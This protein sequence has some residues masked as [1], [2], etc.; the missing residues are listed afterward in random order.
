MVRCLLLVFTFLAAP[1]L[2][3][4]VE[5]PADQAR[6]ELVLDD[7]GAQ[8]LAGQMVL[9]TIRGIYA[10]NI[11]REELKLRRM[12][13]VDWIRLGQD[14]WSQQR[15]DGRSLRVMERRIALYPKA[16]GSLT[17]LPVAHE[18][19]Y[20]DAGARRRTIIRSAPVTLTV[21]PAPERDGAAWL[22]ARAVE[23]SDEW[24]TDAAQLKDGESAER[25]VILRVFGATPE[26]LPTQPPMRAPWLITFSPPEHRSQQLT[27]Q[28]PVT[29]VIWRWTLRPTTGELGV[30]PAVTIPWF[31]T[32][33]GQARTLTIPAAPIGYLSFADNSAASW[34]TGFAGGWLAVAVWG[35]TVTLALSVL[36]AGRAIVG[37]PRDTARRA[38]IRWRLRRA[39]R[40]QVRT[41]DAE[42]FRTT[43]VALLR[44]HGGG[45]PQDEHAVLAPLDAQVFGRPGPRSGVDLRALR[46]AVLGL[47]RS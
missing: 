26:M 16:T 18:L 40:R 28:G 24:S 11:T 22:P 43:A 9:A 23:L 27:P 15:I 14:V 47:L 29:T 8:P 21:R 42:A 6:L 36:A 34:R 13:G 46:K 44:H 17:L 2:A 19:E 10:V 35:L 32:D 5:L 20:L 3:Q 45:G 7:P 41:Q 25:R 39:L 33:A 37:V 38:L 31:D 12:N 4:G 1:A 30:L